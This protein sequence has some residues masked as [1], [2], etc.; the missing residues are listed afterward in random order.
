MTLKRKRITKQDIKH[1]S[2]VYNKPR[3][4]LACKECGTIVENVVADTSAITCWRCV[5]RMVAPPD[6]PVKAKPP[7]E[8]R[9]RGWQFMNEYRAPDGTLYRRGVK[10]DEPIPTEPTNSPERTRKRK[11]NASTARKETGNN[12]GRAKGTKAKSGDKPKPARKSTGKSASRTASKSNKR[13]GRR[14]SV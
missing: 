6:L 10:V 2:R 9:P 3:K 1:D 12:R 4:S 11:T 13:K 5:A 7:E 8:R 14:P